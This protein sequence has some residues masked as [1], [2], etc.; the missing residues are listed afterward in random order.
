MLHRFF[1]DLK[2]WAPVTLQSWG[3]LVD[4]MLNL[5]AE[6]FIG[7]MFGRNLFLSVEHGPYNKFSKSYL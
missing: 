3:A 7:Q 4:S 6:K 5:F 1:L 2:G